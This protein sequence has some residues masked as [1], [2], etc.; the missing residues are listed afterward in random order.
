M[1]LFSKSH[2]NPAEIVKILRDNLAI[3]EKQ[4]KKTDKAS[5][6]VSKS[7]QAMKEILCGTSDKEPPVEAV[8]Q[9]SQELYNTGL[10]VTLIA[11]LQLIDFEGKKDV[12]QIFN[13]ILRRQIGTRIPTVEYI[14]AHPHI[15]FMLLK[16]YEVPQIALR[17]GIMLRECIRHEPLAKIILFSNQFQD[18]FKYVELSTFD[19][20]SDAFATFKIFEDYEKLLQSENYVTKRQSLKLLGE[21]ILDRHNFAI[22][23]KYIS[24]PE[25]LKLTMNLLRDKSPNIQFEAFHVFKV[26]VASPHKTQPIVEILLKNQPKLIEF[27]SNFQKE[28]TDDEQFTDEKN[29]LIKQIRDLKKVAP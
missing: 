15:L 27:L 13:N 28:R 12:T 20:A 1:P 11:D 17:C 9:L 25:N 29:Y 14:S 2:K 3:L 16:G 5:E 4:D 8:A 19:I 6:E 23:T 26:F 22:M 18:F 10:L 24:K 7:L 21:L